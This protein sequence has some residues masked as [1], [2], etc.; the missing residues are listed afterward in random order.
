MTLRFVAGSA[1]PGMYF[2]WAAAE[3]IASTPALVRNSA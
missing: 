2:S 1:E 3:K